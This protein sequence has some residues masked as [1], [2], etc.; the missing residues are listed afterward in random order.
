MDLCPRPTHCQCA[1]QM[2][3]RESCP[4]QKKNSMDLL[5]SERRNQ[6]L[7]PVCP[8]QPEDMTYIVQVLPQCNLAGDQLVGE[9]VVLLLQSHV[10]FLQAP[11][12]ALWGHRGALRDRD[13]QGQGQGL[14]R[15]VLALRAAC[16]YTLMPT[17]LLQY[18]NTTPPAWNSL[19]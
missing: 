11:V 13:R 6:E 19:G 4:T 17:L 16:A 5:S 9:V 7:A 18:A 15:G 14:P 8:G 3:R 10:G 1:I 12:L 2:W